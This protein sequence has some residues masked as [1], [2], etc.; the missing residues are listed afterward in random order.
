MTLPWWGVITRPSTGTGSSSFGRYK[1][2]DGGLDAVARAEQNMPQ[3]FEIGFGL[4]WR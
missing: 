4:G 2:V 1:L 3:D